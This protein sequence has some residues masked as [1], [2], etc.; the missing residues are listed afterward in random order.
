MIPAKVWRSI[1][2]FLNKGANALWSADPVAQMQYEYDLAV[3]QLKT[4]REGLEQHRAWWSASADKWSRPSGIWPCSKRRSRPIWPPAIVNRRRSFA[5]EL[6]R[7][8]S[9][10][11]RKR[12]S[13][14]AARSGLHQ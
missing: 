11:G 7:A 10:A 2:G 13:A 6:E 8:A 5:L 3:T 12:K 14:R 9:R 1:K 4:G